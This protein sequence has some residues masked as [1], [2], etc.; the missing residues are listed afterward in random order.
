MAEYEAQRDLQKVWIHCDMDA[1]YAACHVQ[2]EPSLDDGPMAVGGGI[3]LTANYKARTFGVRSA[4]PGH[5]AKRLCPQ[6]TIV[7]A[8]Y[9]R[10]HAASEAIR[11]VF[12]QFDPTP[13]LAGLDEGYLEVSDY[14][15]KHHN[16]TGVE[17]AERLKRR[18]AEA[19]IYRCS[20]TAAGAG[21]G[22]GAGADAGGAVVRPGL[23]CSVGVAP[24]RMLAKLCSEV[25]KPDGVFALPADRRTILRFLSPLPCAL[26]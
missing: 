23:T 17:V 6:L 18:V 15:R 12:R 24:N 13:M 11:A 10:Y 14:C 3:I 1:F 8:E 26:S 25:N 7:E 21:A 20:A 4:M 22:A 16:I 19:T 9:E 2:V 5:I